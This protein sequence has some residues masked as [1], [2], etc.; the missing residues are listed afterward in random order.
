VAPW[1]LRILVLS[2]SDLANSLQHGLN[3]LIV[4]VTVVTGPSNVRPMGRKLRKHIEFAH[5]IPDSERS[6]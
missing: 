5:I 2:K 1:L 6:E 3:F 4:P